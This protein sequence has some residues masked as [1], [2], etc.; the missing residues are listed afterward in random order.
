MTVI[1]QAGKNKQLFSN[2]PKMVV[3]KMKLKKGDNIA[4]VAVSK[5]EAIIRIIR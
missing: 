2:I 3:T 4:F 1:Q 5:D